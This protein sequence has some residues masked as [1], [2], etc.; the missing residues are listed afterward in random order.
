M[1]CYY[2][3]NMYLA[4]GLREP[5]KL[6]MLGQPV[7]L[8][9][10]RM[11]AYIL[12]T[13]EDHIVPWRTAYRS[14][15]LLKGESRF[16]LGASGHVAGVVN[17]AGKNR[18]SFWVAK[19]LPADPDAWLAQAIEQPGS[20]WRDWTSWLSGHAG[21]TVKAKKRLGGGTYKAIEPAPGRYVREPAG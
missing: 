15:G 9:R 14:A 12:A 8:G 6:R 10:L 2:L 11:P 4:N 1:Y 16:V 19:S 20:W 7:D 21:A 18:R 5:G 17:P 13:R 3:R